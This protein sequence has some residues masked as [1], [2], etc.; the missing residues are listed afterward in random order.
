MIPEDCCNLQWIGLFW[1][2]ANCGHNG[3]IGIA[4][5]AEMD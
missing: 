1:N 4:I 3:E 2:N 5:L